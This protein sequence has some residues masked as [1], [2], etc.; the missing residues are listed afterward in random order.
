MSTENITLYTSSECPFCHRVE[1][2]LAETGQQHRRQ[3]IS[4]ASKPEWYTSQVNTLGKV[5]TLAYGGPEVPADQPSSESVKI[6]ESLILL[7]FVND[8]DPEHRLL[9]KDPVQRVRVRAFIDAVG[10]ISSVFY[11]SIIKGEDP[12]RILTG[13]ESVQKHLSPTSKYAVG[14]EFTLADASV[15]P[16]FARAEASFKHDAG[17]YPSGTGVKLW[18]SLQN[19]EKFAPFRRYYDT[20]KQRE[21]FKKTFDEEWTRQ[22]YVKRFN[23]TDRGDRKSVV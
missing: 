22:Y 15:L 20:L 9:P 19:D 6:N 21:S 16:F 5:P 23:L 2:A 4:L 13:I 17:L 7:D 10:A 14:D 18:E 1:L 8:I 3:E 11:G 12:H